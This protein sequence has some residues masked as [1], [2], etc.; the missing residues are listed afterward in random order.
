VAGAS[1]FEPPATTWAADN[2]AVT[3]TD[4]E[5]HVVF[6]APGRLSKPT[7]AASAADTG[8]PWTVRVASADPAKVPSVLARNRRM[9]FGGLA[10]VGLLISVG[11]FLVA[12]ALARELAVARLQSDFVAAVSHEFRSPLTAMKHLVEMLDQGAVPSEDRR[13]QYYHVLSGETDRLHQMVENLLNFGRMEAGKA[14]YRFEHL[15]IRALVEQVVSAFADGANV[16]ERLT[17]SVVGPPVRVNADGEALSRALWNLLDNAAKYSPDTAP[18]QVALEAS[19]E[20]VSISVRDRGPGIP[21]TERK[22]I[23]AKFYRGAEAKTS[24]VKGTGLGLAT[25]QH[26]VRAHRGRVVVDSTP[27]EGSTFTIELPTGN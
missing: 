3:L 12:R 13:R 17:M 19:A 25:V 23:F 8:L 27:G 1:W 21:P 24:G 9:L 10:V 14:E 2:L 16:R 11:G 7:V 20:T 6:G 18:L 22:Q 26:I 5:S 4:T 15:D